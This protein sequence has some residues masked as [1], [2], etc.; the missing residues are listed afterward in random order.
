MA[1]ASDFPVKSM[2]GKYDGRKNNGATKARRRANS[3]L[4][5]KPIWAKNLTRNMAAV[6]LKENSAKELWAKLLNSSDER[7]RLETLRYLT[8]RLEG[9]PFTAINPAAEGQPMLQDNRLQVAIQN[10]V[11]PA[12]EKNKAKRITKPV[13]EPKALPESNADLV[14]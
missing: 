12:I 5:R 7:I 1:N 8:D 10:L 13:E 2:K 11:L 4:G 9:K 3:K 6:V 14:N